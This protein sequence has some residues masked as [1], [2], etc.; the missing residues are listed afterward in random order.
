MAAA[1]TAGLADVKETSGVGVTNV[2]I[3]PFGTG[4]VPVLF[5]GAEKLIFEKAVPETSIVLPGVALAAISAV[6]NT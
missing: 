3:P 5:T 4:S 6:T 1:G 2:F